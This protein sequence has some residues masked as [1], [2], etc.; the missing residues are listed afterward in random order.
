M[1]IILVPT[2]LFKQSGLGRAGLTLG[3]EGPGSSGV[4]SEQDLNFI[5]EN[6]FD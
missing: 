1:T 5:Q 2:S 3:W 4:R 6:Y